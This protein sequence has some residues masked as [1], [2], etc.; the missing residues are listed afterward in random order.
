MLSHF[1]SKKSHLVAQ[2][3]L[4]QYTNKVKVIFQDE[5]G[6]L[7]LIGYDARIVNRLR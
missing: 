6:R 7:E 5:A 1:L 4:P 3:P 2:M